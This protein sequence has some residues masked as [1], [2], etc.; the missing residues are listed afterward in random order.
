MSEI[1]KTEAVVLNKMN[2]G[3][4]S[5]ISK[6]FTSDH[7]IVSI[8]VKGARSSKSKYGAVVDP[9]NY[10][11]V[12]Y[13]KKE[14][15]DLQ[16]LSGAEIIS[17]FPAIKEDL[18]KLKYAY[19]T[20]ELVK[21]LLAENESNHKI[22]KGLVRI[23]E[24][25]N[26]ADEKPGISFGRFFLFFLR[27]IGYELQF[28]KCIVCGTSS[29]TDNNLIYSF[30]KGLLCGK[31]KS[32]A[33]EF[34]EINMELITYLNCLKTNDKADFYGD[35]I[36]LKAIKFMEQHLKFQVPNFKGLQSF[37]IISER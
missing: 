28:D 27:E 8:I 24:K 9:I 20:V 18:T 2:Y 12:I 25:I 6:L 3:D 37:Q 17:H 21:N 34:Y 35:A 36:I 13:Y 14:T 22:F 11:Q 15:R 7:G 29:F 10:L 31:C 4:T 16:L 1:I 33:V 30:E 19:A 26:S 5:I 23:L 32:Q